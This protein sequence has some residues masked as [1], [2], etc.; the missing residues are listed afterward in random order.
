[1]LYRWRR[2]PNT[3]HRSKSGV[4]RSERCE[5]APS[6]FLLAI[7]PRSGHNRTRH[8][9]RPG[10]IAPMSRLALGLVVALMLAAGL[11][12]L[13]PGAP[14][15]AAAPPPGVES[16]VVNTFSIVAHDPDRKEW[17]VGVA[18]KYLAVGSV[19]PWAK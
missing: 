17:G 4:R 10:G 8:S 3:Q 1:W 16:P 12:L 13:V 19:V 15:P 14:A 18:S 6:F 5:R 7:P 9:R 2:V 11:S